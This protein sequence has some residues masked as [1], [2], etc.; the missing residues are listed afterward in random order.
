MPMS[1]GDEALRVELFGGPR[2]HGGLTGPVRLSP[3]QLA[4]VAVVY[5]HAPAPVPRARAAGLLWDAEADSDAR[6]RIRQLLVEIRSRCRGLIETTHD[7][8]LAPAEVVC[9]LAHFEQALERGTLAEAAALAKRGFAQLALTGVPDSYGDWRD[10]VHA[11]VV[12]RL[13][14]RAS[15]AWTRGRDHGDWRDARDAAEALYCLDPAGAD[16]VEKVVEARARTGDL[17]L[18][19]SAYAAFMESQGAVASDAPIHE[20]IRRGRSAW[21]EPTGSRATEAATPFVGRA[22]AL[23]LARSHLEHVQSGQFGML[24]IG[25]ESGIGKTRLLRELQREARFRDFRSLSAQAVELESRIP[26]NPL[27]DALRDVDLGPHLDRL[28]TPWSAVIAAVL[29]P[30]TLS[31][32]VG[33]LPPIQESALPRRLLDALSLLLQSLAR[34]Q[35]TMLFVDDLHWADTTTIT[36]LQFMQRRWAGGPLGV[37]A[38][39][40]TDLVRVDEP[41]ARYLSKAEG[42]SAV[43]IELQE[44]SLD[45]GMELVRGVSGGRIEDG[46]CR[47][48]CALAGLH[49][50]C[51]MELTRDHMSGRLTLPATPA[52][53]LVIPVSLEQIVGA[54]LERLDPPSRRMAGFLAVAAKPMT[55]RTLAA[56]AE[57]SLDDVADA[58]ETLRRARLVEVEHE[59][60]R[61]VHELFRSAIY[62]DLGEPRRSL[63]HR[64]IAE[65]VLAA[66]GED[67]VGELAIH[68]DRA[69]ECELAAKYGWIAADR[70]METGTVAEAG[71]LYQLVSKN[72]HDPIKR[73]QATAGHARALHL[74]RD[75]VRANPMLELAALQL[76]EVGRHAEALPLEIRRI[77]GLA[78]AGNI[79]ISVL[80]DNL[81]QLKRQASD[82]ACWEDV[83]LALDVELHLLSRV[84]DFVGIRRVFAEMR[85]VATKG[86]VDATILANA[87]LALGV[88]FGD[89]AEA[90]AA[91]ERAVELSGAA[92]TYRLVALIRLL[93]VLQY[94]G[95][96]L[97]PP[98]EPVLAEARAL[99]ERTGDV[100]LRF[101]I[102]GNLAVGCLDAGDLEGAESRM[103]QPLGISG[104]ANMNLN[105]S[106]EANNRAELALAQGDY[107]CAAKIYAEAASYLGP[108]TPAFM[109]D[110]IVA[111]LGV[112]ALEQGN[113][114]EARRCERELHPPPKRWHF[115]PTTILRFRSQLLERR[116]LRDAAIELLGAASVDLQ[117]RLVLAWLKVRA[118][119][120]RLMLKQGAPE[121]ESIAVEARNEALKLSL[122]HRAA[123]FDHLLTRLAKSRGQ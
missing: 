72:E 117:G 111:G 59:R 106:S 123:E 33:E 71:Q 17:D 104:T 85:D 43:R 79:P 9:D 11:S 7:A 14:G 120:V 93:V 24:L 49:P 16:A 2:V 80:T 109:H 22:D 103:A 113:L 37:I 91:A 101:S 84:E 51:L 89:P 98:A 56:L 78:E 76:R 75:I 21:R 1:G 119:Q 39:V 107:A 57:T 5:G 63:H 12:R 102:E 67:S 27:L 15:A 10:G 121:A 3:L 64:A 118:L 6:H 94:Q 122:H 26:L 54:R 100:L 97:T 45:D 31:G 92:R 105:R 88:L 47:R 36:A 40:R 13:K 81:A 34:E 30:G 114:P 20:I 96:L 70:A 18:A 99:A 115:D 69:G 108:T 66:G 50:M 74:A 62:R 112:C 83:A 25:G 68:Y 44:M 8:L 86:S 95:R 35:P 28:G 41:V 19:E 32:P 61:I 46:T 58:V 90:L 29:P 65:H 23:R 87:G 116:G 38:T 110:L 55:I 73:A 52:T 53:E 48:I 82:S 77:E 4:L 42:L 60:I